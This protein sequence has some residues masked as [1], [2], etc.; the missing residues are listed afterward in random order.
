MGMVRVCDLPP[1]GSPADRGS[2]DRYYGRP[3]NPH[4]YPEGTYKGE[5]IIPPQMTPKQV[6]EYR[7][8]FDTEE[9]RKDWGVDCPS[10]YECDT[11][12]A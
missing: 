10:H 9:D 7:H 8:G 11:E 2:A 1:N 4:Y 12:E 5:R 3:F 6:E